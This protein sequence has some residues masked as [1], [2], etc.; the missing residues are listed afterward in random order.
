M[1]KE[2]LILLIMAALLLLGMLLTL[3]LGG[4]SSRHGYGA[5]PYP[6]GT[7]QTHYHLLPAPSHQAKE[8]PLLI[9]KDQE[10]AAKAFRQLAG[11]FT[12]LLKPL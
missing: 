2:D 7:L 10:N 8:S 9:E 4:E 1:K 6:A 11:A 3:L 5:L 12:E